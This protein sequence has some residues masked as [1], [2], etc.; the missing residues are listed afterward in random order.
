MR[1]VSM[2]VL[3]AVVALS[4]VTSGR[5][6][7]TGQQPQAGRE[8]PLLGTWKQVS[9]KFNGKEFRPPEGTT[10]LKH[11]TRSQYMFVDVDKDGQI[12][13]AAGGPYKLT[14]DRYEE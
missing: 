8:H 11:V 4:A 2:V 6:T 5:S 9:A 13:D 7:V 10:L 12:R 3:A 14:A 1:Q